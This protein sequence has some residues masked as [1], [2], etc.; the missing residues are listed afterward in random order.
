M[1]TSWA[2]RRSRFASGSSSSSSRGR[3]I[4]ACAIRIR[5]C[6]PPD[7]RPTRSSANDLASTASSISCTRRAA[8]A[9][10]QRDAEPVAVEPERDQVPAAQRHVRV[11][12]ELLRDVAEIAPP[13][14]GRRRPARVPRR[15]ACC[16][17]R[18]T[19]N[20]VVLPAPFEPIRPVNSPARIE[21]LTS[22][23]TVRPPSRT[24][25]PST[26]S[27]SRGSA[28]AGA[29]VL[30]SASRSRRGRRRPAAAR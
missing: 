17:P 3:L 5:C 16:R 14:D 27:A 8:L 18:I 4:S 11:E 29:S 1:T 9:R 7:S 28:A 10:G 6:S 12:Q 24:V 26:R 2:L 19:R 23:S 15:P 25:T 30:T 22:S 20:S 13:T 21:K